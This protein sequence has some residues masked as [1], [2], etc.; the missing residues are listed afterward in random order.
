[1]VAGT[2]PGPP[3]ELPPVPSPLLGCYWHKCRDGDEARQFLTD[4]QVM[5]VVEAGLV[6]LI[7][8]RPKDPCRWLSAYLKEHNPAAPVQEHRITVLGVPV[9]CVNRAPPQLIAD[10]PLPVVPNWRQAG[11]LPVFGMAHVGLD[12]W[13]RV[14]DHVKKEHKIGRRLV[15]I[16]VD[17]E[18]VVFVRHPPRRVDPKKAH[19]HAWLPYTTDL[20][21]AVSSWNATHA[22]PVQLPSD[23]KVTQIIAGAIPP[24]KGENR[25]AGDLREVIAE[26]SR[27]RD[28]RKIDLE[29]TRVPLGHRSEPPGA[30]LCDRVL[31]VLKR[32]R[33]D[34]T[35]AIP[36]TAVI[37]VS[38]TG[39]ADVTMGMLLC[40]AVLSAYA[41]TQGAV[42]RKRAWREKMRVR[43]VQRRSA[44]AEVE[45]DLR[46]GTERDRRIA[47]KAEEHVRM[48]A[49]RGVEEAPEERELRLQADSKRTARRQAQRDAWQDYLT[50]AKIAACTKIAAMFRGHRERKRLRR[51]GNKHKAAARDALERER[52]AAAAAAHAEARLYHERGCYKVVWFF[53]RRLAARMGSAELFQFVEPKHAGGRRCLQREVLV[54][55]VRQTPMRFDPNPQSAM[56]SA[57]DDRSVA[58][59]DCPLSAVSCASRLSRVSTPP[60]TEDA[61]DDELFS[62]RYEEDDMP[63]AEDFAVN[64]LREVHSLI[65]SCAQLG[66]LRHE[67]YVVRHQ[68]KGVPG[69]QQRALRAIEST[70][71]LVMFYSWLVLS[72]VEEMTILDD[73]IPRLFGVLVSQPKS[74]G[75]EVQLT[76]TL[77]QA[78]KPYSATLA[79]SARRLVECVCPRHF[80][81]WVETQY[82]D[83]NFCLTNHHVLMSLAPEPHSFPFPAGPP[84]ALDDRIFVVT[85]PVRTETAEAASWRL[86]RKGSRRRS[87]LLERQ[88]SVATAAG[89]DSLAAAMETPGGARSPSTTVAG[90]WRRET[91]EG[92]GPHRA[93]RRAHRKLPL[94]LV[95]D[96][97]AQEDV[98]DLRRH[99]G[100]V[101]S[102]LWLSTAPHPSVYVGQFA[103]AAQLA[104]MH[105][106]MRGGAPALMLDTAQVVHAPGYQLPYH[107]SAAAREENDRMARKASR[108]RLKE[109]QKAA[110]AA[111]EKAAVERAQALAAAA[112][113]GAGGP[114]TDLFGVNM[115]RLEERLAGAVKQRLLAQQGQFTYWAGT[116]DEAL[117]E[118]K[119]EVLALAAVPR[120]PRDNVVG[121]ASDEAAAASEERV[122]HSLSHQTS[123]NRSWEKGVQDS[124]AQAAMS[125]PRTSSPAPGVITHRKSLRQNS[126][127]SLGSGRGARQIASPRVLDVV[128]SSRRVSVRSQLSSHPSEHD[129]APAV[130]PKPTLPSSPDEVVFTPAEKLRRLAE[131]SFPDLSCSVSGA[132]D[133]LALQVHRLPLL[134]GVSSHFLRGVSVIAARVGAAVRSAAAPKLAVVVAHAQTDSGGA[135]L[136]AIA[137]IAYNL[138]W[139]AEHGT[140]PLEVIAAE[141]RAE[142]EAL[143]RKRRKSEAVLA[144]MMMGESQQ[145]FPP[146]ETPVEGEEDVSTQEGSETTASE[147]DES[148]FDLTTT[149][150]LRQSLPNAA[151]AVEEEEDPFAALDAQAEPDPTVSPIPCV[152]ALARSPLGEALGLPDAVRYVDFLLEHANKHLDDGLLGSIATALEL[153]QTATSAE[154]RR[155]T[156]LQAVRALERYV[157]V[158]FFHCWL[159]RR[160]D[161]ELQEDL[162]DWLS[163]T[164]PE[165][166][167]WLR[168]LNPW[169]DGQSP[170][171]GHAA[172][173]RARHRWTTPT[174]ISQ[175]S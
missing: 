54:P 2:A 144:E 115:S 28:S 169:P 13:K 7:R 8:E 65:D 173:T 18:D 46:R 59:S 91:S 75:D 72:C 107:M 155:T 33:S 49:S 62:L 104:P 27:S 131:A 130:P 170:A 42:V 97:L 79:E 90:D 69:I 24:A 36:N 165:A 55:R 111:A 167:Q 41:Q 21:Q 162:A 22:A 128:S 146:A 141:R 20:H 37:V 159:R 114:G 25:S 120:S 136:L 9:C 44:I 30:Q 34:L 12:G 116:D 47:E 26:A 84:H 157:T 14:I 112:E 133:T 113:P 43:D 57:A 142:L 63:A 39:K 92:G 10:S 50:G 48:L 6:R 101:R 56:L 138:H 150:R 82:D 153:A 100:E 174:A 108:K 15:V 147:S 151:V 129:H 58:A 105:I 110:M 119:D 52:E 19:L 95:Q 156:V 166:L 99:L 98:D 145:A 121:F 171:P 140:D 132:V 68:Y 134:Q 124:P 152:D 5:S 78:K 102:L 83:V 127:R 35:S 164:H 4:R 117:S 32:H 149:Q 76:V 143:E 64:P 38:L 163:G 31:S 123:S 60:P 16:G 29:V 139:A 168:H 106:A 158:L 85:L 109:E 160:L 53:L 93:F 77:E 88:G 1:M 161:G 103:A 94:Y 96:P 51:K 80:A 23:K 137:T 67:L 125:D 175:I 118:R 87:H 66:N 40:A 74:Q 89:D 70:L 126:N 3:P 73:S 17:D 172:W 122:H 135:M 11:S 81:D 61:S 71:V 86:H 154:Q 45:A 148:L